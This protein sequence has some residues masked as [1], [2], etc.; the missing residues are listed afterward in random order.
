MRSCTG[1]ALI[2]FG[3]LEKLVVSRFIGLEPIRLFREVGTDLGLVDH[4]EA[5]VG[6][7]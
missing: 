1:C 4:A 6:T 7:L 5:F 2:S 3:V